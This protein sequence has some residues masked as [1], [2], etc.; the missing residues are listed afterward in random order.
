MSGFNDGSRRRK[1]VALLLLAAVLA[2]EAIGTAAVGLLALVASPLGDGVTSGIAVAVFVLIL[3]VLLA[4]VAVGTLRARPWTRSAT[5]V[6]QLIQALVG[7]YSLQG[8]GADLR[9][10][11]P[12]LVLAVGGL[13]LLFTRAV[14]EA[15]ERA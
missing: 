5:L 3:A 10:G 12:A 14:R 7:A 2:V 1:P 9:F 11:V 13:V 15:T 8:A 4:V 6:W